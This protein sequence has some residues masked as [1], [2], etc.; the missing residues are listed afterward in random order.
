MMVISSEKQTSAAHRTNKR[1]IGSSVNEEVQQAKRP[2]LLERTNHTR[3]RCLDEKGRQT[4]R[5]LE[6]DEDVK[7]WPQSKADKYF[8]GLPLVCN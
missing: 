4:W 2:K 1:P 5:Y 3:W 6:D 7:E 8:L